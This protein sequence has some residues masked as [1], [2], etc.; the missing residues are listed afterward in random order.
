M[1]YI[2]TPSYDAKVHA[3][4]V[5]GLLDLRHICSVNNIGFAMDMIPGNAFVGHGRDCL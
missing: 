3:T 4:T 2:G 1:L 5:A